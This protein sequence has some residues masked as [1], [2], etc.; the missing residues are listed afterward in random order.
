MVANYR[1]PLILKRARNCG[2]RVHPICIPTH[3]RKK[4]RAARRSCISAAAHCPH[5]R[6]GDKIRQRCPLLFRHADLDIPSAALPV[7]GAMKPPPLRI[8]IR[9]PA[10][11]SHWRDTSASSTVF[12]QVWRRTAAIASGWRDAPLC[13]PDT[14]AVAIRRE[15]ASLWAGYLA[16]CRIFSRAAAGR[17]IDG[18]DARS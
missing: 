9:Y 10:N 5:H 12:I 14:C 15:Y 4:H 11:Q 1:H 18:A 6:C 16:R 17:P 13:V 3:R 2:T 7:S 8:H